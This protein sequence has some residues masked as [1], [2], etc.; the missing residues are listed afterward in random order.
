MEVDLD[1]AAL[2]DRQLRIERIQVQDA[3]IHLD[4]GHL[5][6]LGHSDRS[7]SRD[8]FR[9]TVDSVRLME[10]TLVLQTAS[11]PP[12]SFWI[13]RLDLTGL[14]SL[15][16]G[17]SLDL[18]GEIDVSGT[19]VA[20]SVSAGPADE[21]GSAHWPFAVRMQA[22]DA[23]LEASGSTGA[24]FDITEIEARVDLVA[25]EL[26][27]L[28]PL[29]PTY[30]LTA[31]GFRLSGR[32][33]RG[34]DEL[35]L[36]RIEG[37]L[38]APESLGRITLTD[39]AARQVANGLT[40]RLDG[41]IGQTPFRLKLEFTGREEGQPFNPIQSGSGRIDLSATLGDARL[42][43]DLSLTIDGPR[44]S[45]EGNL[46]IEKLD[47]PAPAS[48]NRSIAKTH[49]AG[50]WLDHPIPV[51]RLRDLDLNL[52]LRIEALETEPLKNDLLGKADGHLELSLGAGRLHKKAADP[53]PLG[54]LLFTLLD[55]LNPIALDLDSRVHDN[56]LQCAVL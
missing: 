34:D 23:S 24:P 9:V 51:G 6:D 16:S 14:D 45:I 1:L 2:F 56:D 30:A 46:N 4:P 54:G 53:L 3:V 33:V 20:I 40:A 26:K 41:E 36:D 11:D 47:L 52:A 10:S 31:G 50:T 29:L 48:F 12:R 5:G 21:S 17:P 28:Q 22:A 18:E 55:V 8:G 25:P 19:P 15:G 7:S 44:P 49:E 13:D 42:V 43:G 39:G 32:L 27:A 35:A 37:S 38:D